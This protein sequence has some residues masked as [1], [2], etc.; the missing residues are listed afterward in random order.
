MK[1]IFQR[2]LPKTRIGENREREREKTESCIPI[3]IILMNV[4]VQG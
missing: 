1:E 2:V 3:Y 4:S